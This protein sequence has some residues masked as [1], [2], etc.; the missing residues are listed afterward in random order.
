V[1]F[2]AAF[3]PLIV[4]AEYKDSI[5]KTF[6]VRDGGNLLID[7]DLGAIDIKTG[8]SDKVIIHII[9]EIKYSSGEEQKEI[10]DN[11]ELTID[12]K[13][14][15]VIIESRMKKK[16]NG[17]FALFFRHPD[18]KLNFEVEIPA[19]F[20]VDLKTGGGHI[21]VADLT[22][23]VICNTSGGKIE[24][25]NISGTVSAK[26]SGGSIKLDGA[27]GDA[28]LHTSGGSIKIG[29]VEGNVDAYTSGGRI[30]I[31]R[32]GGN[33]KA[34]TSGGSIKMDEV[35]GVV[36]ASTSGGSIT[37]NISE[38]PA[39]NCRFTSSGGS[40]DIFVNPNCK[41]SINASTSGGGVKTDVPVTLTGELS[42]NKL[43]ADMNGGGPELYIQ[44]SGG[45]IHILKK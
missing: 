15:E 1:L 42:K 26:T 9:R 33:V 3:H 4:S 28:D 22:G 12:Q 8:K 34:Y 45:R 39:A 23:K 38:Q 10:L 43:V 14:N 41:L 37:A 40:I 21:T 36:D 30:E 29:S 13:G 24:I 17:I 2:V 18:F 31:I 11:L 6:T 32:A 27:T 16:Y 35:K 19:K 25:K 44:T 7:S 5:D 20:N